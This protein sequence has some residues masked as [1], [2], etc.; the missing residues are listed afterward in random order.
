MKRG[1]EPACWRSLEVDV[2]CA[3]LACMAWQHGAR[4]ATWPANKTAGWLLLR[5]VRPVGWLQTA[6]GPGTLCYPPSG[7]FFP[8]AF[9]FYLPFPTVSPLAKHVTT[10]VDAP[11]PPPFPGDRSDRCLTL[12]EWDL[13]PNCE[14]MRLQHIFSRRSP[15]PFV[16]LIPHPSL[17]T[18]SFS[19]FVCVSV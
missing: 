18:L 15:I 13:D 10:A 7:I 1:T 3:T 5:C 19:L 12:A 4:R 11:P 9:L 17:S 16:Y 2:V 14:T 6:F 8:V